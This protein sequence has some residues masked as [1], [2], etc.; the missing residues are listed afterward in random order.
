MRQPKVGGFRSL[1]KAKSQ[2]QAVLLRNAIKFASNIFLMKFY[3]NYTFWGFLFP[4]GSDGNESACRIC[5]RRCRFHATSLG[6]EVH[7][8]EGLATHSSILAWEIRWTEESGRL[9]Y[10]GPQRVGYD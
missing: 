5:S 9:Q 4:C 8:E 1:G 3:K 2:A 10:I 6:Q 7:L